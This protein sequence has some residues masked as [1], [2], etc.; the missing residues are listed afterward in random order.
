MN[1][2]VICRGVPASGK[3]TWAREWVAEAPLRA[4]VCR[5]DLRFAMFGLYWGL[6]RDQEDAVTLVQHAAVER[7]LRGH[8]D[9]VVDDTNLRASSFKGLAEVAVRAGAAY[10]HQDFP[11]ELEEAIR[12]DQHRQNT[13]QR[14]VGEAAIR[15][16]FEK[17]IR[18]GELPP[19]PSHT[20][21]LGLPDHKYVPDTSLPA[22]WI[23]DIDGTLAHMNGRGPFEWHRVGEDLPNL[24]VVEMVQSL[25][26]V[27]LV[28]V[29]GRDECCRD[30]TENWLDDHRIPWDELLMRPEGDTRK[31]SVVKA[32]IF[33][34]DIAPHWNVRG[35]LDDRNQVVDMW[36]GLGLTCLQVAPGDF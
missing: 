11:I 23:V 6:T 16:F 2:L 19:V 29:S 31:D 8:R 10:R 12:R 3:T 27:A 15:G 28:A 1:E 20:T 34:R 18:K 30:Q 14:C 35:V 21:D 17:F 25:E 5:D 22:A 33:W 13:G 24:P 4:R 9:V 36:R 32:E 7:L 26:D